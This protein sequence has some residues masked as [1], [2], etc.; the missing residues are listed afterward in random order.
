MIS[1][2]T[3][4]ALPPPQPPAVAARA[5]SEAAR[6]AAEAWAQPMDPAESGRAASQLHSVLRDLG[7]ATRGLAR[8][9]TNG[10]PAD[11][12]PLEF[13]RLVAAGAQRFVEAWE[14]LDG[15]VAAEGL[16][17]VPD[18][19]EPGA[20]LCRAAR[21][22]ITA[23]RQPTGT[24]EDRDTTV[25]RLIAATGYLSA[26]TQCLI[27]FAPRQRA[28]ALRAVD[29]AMAAATARLSG[30]IQPPV[31]KARPGRRR[32]GTADDSR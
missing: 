2:R 32:N 20:V 11:P 25:R 3:A 17:A 9:Q 1:G 15:V 28:I 31:D 26:A 13:S 14:S 23:W 18:P 21:N 7:I 24:S 5:V 19:G 12:A 4:P 8:F 22:T 29:A 6:A 30:A 10:R 27:T 16:G